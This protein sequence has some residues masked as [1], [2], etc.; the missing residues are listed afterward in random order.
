[1]RRTRTNKL[2]CSDCVWLN[3]KH[4]HTNIHADR[5]L[6]GKQCTNNV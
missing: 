6:V 3:I 5:V 4:T 2:F 1:M